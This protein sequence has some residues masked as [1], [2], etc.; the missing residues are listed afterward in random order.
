MREGAHARERAL[1]DAAVAEFEAWAAAADRRDAARALADR[2]E[3]ERVEAL[4]A[5]W[6]RVPDIAPEARAA[7]EQMSR[8]LARRV[9]REPLTRLAADV[10]GEHER[11][12]RRLWT[13]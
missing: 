13:L 6:R 3:A 12:I 1:V 9:V 10:D 8:H 7:V 2:V 4:A 11:A 5:L